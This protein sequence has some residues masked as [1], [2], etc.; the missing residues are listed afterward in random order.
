MF[1]IGE[2]IA[3]CS[4]DRIWDSETDELFS[5]H[6]QTIPVGTEIRTEINAEIMY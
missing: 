2:I 6:F 1:V 4:V 5:L 3:I